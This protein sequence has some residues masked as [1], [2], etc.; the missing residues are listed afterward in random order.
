MARQPSSSSAVTSDATTT[1][2]TAT[3]WEVAFRSDIPMITVASHT[4]TPVGASAVGLRQPRLK[5][6]PANAPVRNGHAV[7]VTPVRDSPSA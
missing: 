1:K 6:Q 7:C 4:V 2:L 3:P 5:S